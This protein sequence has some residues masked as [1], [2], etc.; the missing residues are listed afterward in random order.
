MCRLW[1]V[2]LVWG[3]MRGRE[4]LCCGGYGI[5][6]AWWGIWCFL[7]GPSGGGKSTILGLVGEA[8]KGA[9]GFEVFEFG[10]VV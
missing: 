5:D 2:C 1:L 6:F 10:A 8:V 9:D 7:T 3:L 4:V